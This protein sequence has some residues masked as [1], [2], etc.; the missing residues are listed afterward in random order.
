MLL[1]RSTEAAK[2]AGILPK[3]GKARLIFGNTLKSEVSLTING[4]TIKM[5]AGEGEKKPDGPSLD[6]A[7]GKHNLSMTIDGKPTTEELELEADQTW[8]VIVLEGGP[9]PL[10]MY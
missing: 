3:P 2:K 7:P 6:L 5:R 4:K 9:L 1:T 8:G 10:L